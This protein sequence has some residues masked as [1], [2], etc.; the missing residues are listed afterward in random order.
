M[1]RIMVKIAHLFSSLKAWN[2]INGDFF[3]TLPVMFSSSS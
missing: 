2:D 1:F 3:L